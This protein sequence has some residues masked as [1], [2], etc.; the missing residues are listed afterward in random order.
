MEPSAW[1]AL[2]LGLIAVSKGDDVHG[3]TA[4]RT[5]EIASAGG[6][7]TEAD[8]RSLRK[9]EAATAEP[10]NAVIGAEGGGGKY[11]TGMPVTFLS[12]KGLVPPY[13]PLW[14]SSGLDR[15]HPYHTLQ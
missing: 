7:A 6:S 11:D 4:D 1:Q 5:H 9:D 13:H 14:R 8:E 10:A 15:D 2:S 12:P 3:I